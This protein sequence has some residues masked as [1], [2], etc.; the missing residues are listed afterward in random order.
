MLR[1][2]LM[3]ARLIL[4]GVAIL[5]MAYPWIGMPVQAE[6]LTFNNCSTNNAGDV[7]T[8]EAQMQVEVTDLG[9]GQV[10]FTFRNLGPNT[11]S[12]ADVYFDDGTLLGIADLIDADQN[13][14]DAGVDFSQDA[15]PGDLPAGNNC[16]GGAFQATAGFTADSD[17]PVQPNGV[18]PN[19][20]LGVIFD[21]QT[22]QTFADV[23]DDLTTGAL[24]IGIHVQGYASGG[25]ESFVNNPLPPPPDDTP[26][27]CQL[28]EVSPG[29]PVTLRV[30]TQDTGSGLN[31]IIVLRS[32]NATV[33]IPSF[34]SGTN[35]AVIVTATKNIPNRSSTVQLQV[36]DVEGNST[37][38]DP[39][40]EVTV[41]QAGR[42]VSRSI[43][44]TADGEE[45]IVINGEPGLTN[46]EIVVNGT[47]FNVAG[48]GDGE[49]RVIDVSSVVEYGSYATYELTARGQPGASAQVVIP[50]V[51]D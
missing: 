10:L 26:P 29:P 30:F 14:G 37:I 1:R 24:R 50:V 15:S 43:S 41:R 20:S 9:G 40:I 33:N 45:V 16:P 32:T 27:I 19:E 46:L 6:I 21:L 42:P 31:Q 22:G 2:T 13:S 8:G 28:I 17:P 7:A 23:L 39:V 3:K 5:T 38:C 36:I 11:S 47:R 44:G 48:L 4:M 34:S 12:I 25:S 51:E 35:D 49:M 18:N